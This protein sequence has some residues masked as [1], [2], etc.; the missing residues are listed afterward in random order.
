MREYAREKKRL[1]ASKAPRATSLPPAR[2]TPS[3]RKHSLL[4]AG[5]AAGTPVRIRPQQ[6]S[7]QK[8]Y[9]AE[10]PVTEENK[11]IQQADCG[12]AGL[13]LRW[14][15]KKVARRMDSNTSRA[16]SRSDS[17]HLAV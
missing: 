16:L 10:E 12:P 9:R 1:C 14:R 8:V 4:F 7:S 6:Q 5:P 3:E 17:Y 2:K 15:M 11:K 13:I